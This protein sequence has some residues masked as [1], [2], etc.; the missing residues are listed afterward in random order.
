MLQ[1]LS[2]ATK[3]SKSNKVKSLQS[4]GG[5]GREN[6]I[7]KEIKTDIKDRSSTEIEG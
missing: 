4:R 6:I 1:G 2:Q 5:Y 3:E 7:T